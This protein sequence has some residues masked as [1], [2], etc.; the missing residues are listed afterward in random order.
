MQL[1]I[2]KAT[3]PLQFIKRQYNNPFANSKRTMEETPI[4]PQGDIL[5]N[6]VTATPNDDIENNKNN[7][8][9]SSPSNESDKNSFVGEVKIADSNSEASHS[10]PIE[11]ASAVEMPEPIELNVSVDRKYNHDAPNDVGGEPPFDVMEN[12]SK[13]RLDDDDNNQSAKEGHEGENENEVESDEIKDA[14]NVIATPVSNDVVHS[15]TPEPVE[16]PVETPDVVIATPPK[17]TASPISDNGN[18]IANEVIHDIKDDINIIKTPPPA[19]KAMNPRPRSSKATRTTPISLPTKTPPNTAVKV[20]KYSHERPGTAP[21]PW[22]TPRKSSIGGGSFEEFLARME[23]DLA[24]REENKRR[25]R[26]H[27]EES[28]KKECTFSPRLVTSTKKAVQSGE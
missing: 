20:K 1:R 24:R 22:K 17:H 12:P 9:S 10:P 5:S 15:I 11:C 6:D 8:I 26:Q 19:K 23:S 16:E 28:E 25:I 3:K 14:G 27:L 13:E 7:F 4:E 18:A 2:N 21:S